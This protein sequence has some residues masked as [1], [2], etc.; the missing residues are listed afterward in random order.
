M[1]KERFKGHHR[2]PQ[3]IGGKDTPA[4]ISNVIIDDHTSWH[5]LFG[6]MNAFQICDCINK[7]EQ[8]PKNVKIVCKFINGTQVKGSGKNNTEDKE[9]IS[10]A[11]NSLFKELKFNEIIDYINSVWLDPSYHLYIE[12]IS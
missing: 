7:M 1:K 9:K 2:R 6:N 11:W 3:S 4:N 5:A 10:S 8:K 12:N